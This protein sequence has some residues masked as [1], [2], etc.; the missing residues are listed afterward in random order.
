MFELDKP[1]AK[2]FF[3]KQII[4]KI[5]QTAMN[6]FSDNKEE[7]PSTEDDWYDPLAI[8]VGPWVENPIPPEVWPDHFDADIIG[9]TLAG[10]PKTEEELRTKLD[11]IMGDFD[12]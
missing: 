10:L 3:P 1:E 5:A 8:R 4:K 2:E 11:E 7:R 9:K 6:T 12:M